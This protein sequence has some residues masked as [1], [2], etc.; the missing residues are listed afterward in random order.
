V[1]FLVARSAAALRAAGTGLPDRRDR[2][3]LGGSSALPLFQIIAEDEAVL[4]RYWKAK[5]T[6]CGLRF[7]SY[8][9]FE[10]PTT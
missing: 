4:Q 9:G 8:G 5:F 6:V 2:D 1:H 7:F 3:I 10:L